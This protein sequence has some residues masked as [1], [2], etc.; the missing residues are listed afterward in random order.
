MGIIICP[1]VNVVHNAHPG[2]VNWQERAREQLSRRYKST[3][4][5]EEVLLTA[6]YSISDNNSFLLFNRDPIDRMIQYL[7]VRQQGIPFK[8]LLHMHAAVRTMR[9]V[10]FSLP[11]R[12]HACF[13]S[14]GKDYHC[15]DHVCVFSPTTQIVSLLGTEICS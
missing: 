5:P 2:Y 1:E 6:L 13:R 3:R 15:N 10:V 8:A 11:T 7:K 14:H 9:M 12:R 4:M